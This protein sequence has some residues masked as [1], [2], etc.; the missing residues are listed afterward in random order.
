MQKA[1][2]GDRVLAKRTGVDNRG[3]PEGAIVEITDRGSAASS[4]DW[5]SSAA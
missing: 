4:G 2:H 3:K 1:M 5:C